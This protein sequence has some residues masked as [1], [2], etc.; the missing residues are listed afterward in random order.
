M[1]VMNEINKLKEGIGC[2]PNESNWTDMTM[3]DRYRCGP[4]NW[5][6]K[7]PIDIGIA[8]TLTKLTKWMTDR[9]RC[10]FEK[11]KLNSNWHGRWPIDIGAAL[12]IEMTWWMTDQDRCGPENW[13][14]K[15]NDWSI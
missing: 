4:D 3:I 5:N 8:P 12:K 7:W 10:G 1:V 15:M 14:D 9:Y 2:D 11:L 6:L 13:T